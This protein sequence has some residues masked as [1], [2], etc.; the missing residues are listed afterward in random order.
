MV[1]VKPINEALLV[2]HLIAVCAIAREL[3]L[4]PEVNPKVTEYLQRLK[5]FLNWLQK[6]VSEQYQR[7]KL[8]KQDNIP[9]M[10]AIWYLDQAHLYLENINPSTF[11]KLMQIRSRLI[12]CHDLYTENN[13]DRALAS[14]QIKCKI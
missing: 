5:I 4:I 3:V 13:S 1:S 14:R 6:E 2:S 7:K 8:Y 10:D 11:E 12:D 9:I